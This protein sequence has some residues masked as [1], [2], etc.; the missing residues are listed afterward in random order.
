MAV[1]PGVVREE[2]DLSLYAEIASSHVFGVVGLFTKGPIGT[3]TA[4]SNASDLVNKFGKPKTTFPAWYAARQYLRAG[5]QLRVVRMESASSPAEAGTGALRGAKITTLESGADGDAIVAADATEFASAGSTFQTNNVQ[6]GDYLRI[7]SGANSGYY[8]VITAVTSETE[9]HVSPDLAADE[10][11]LNFEV[12]TGIRQSKDDGATSVP[13]TRQLTSATGQFLNLAVEAG[14][15]VV[16]AD[17]GTPEDNQLYTVVSVQNAT[18]LTVDRNWPKGS[19]AGLTYSIYAP[20][21]AG[22]DGVTN[23]TAVFTSAGSKFQSTGVL[24]GDLLEIE[25]TIDTGDNAVYKIASV[26]SET[27]L[28]LETTTTVP[29]GLT[30][31]AFQVW[32]SALVGTAIEKGTHASDLRFR[33]TPSTVSRTLYDLEIQQSGVTVEKFYGVD[34]NNL[35][36]VDNAH[37]TFASSVGILT[38][39]AHNEWFSLVGGDDGDTGV[40]DA[41]YI[42]TATALA[43]TAL[44]LFRHPDAVALK[45]LAV[46]GVSTEAVGNELVAIT[47]ERGDI[48]AFLDPPSSA[49]VDSVQDVL[50]WTNG[51]LGRTTAINSNQVA[52]YWPWFLV[53]DEYNAQDVACAPSGA[54]AMAFSTTDKVAA[55]WYAPAGPARGRVKGATDLQYNPTNP[56]REQ[57]Y[58]PGQIVNPISKIG[59]RGVIIFGQKTGQRANTSLNRLNVRRMLNYVQKSIATATQELL[60]EPN[61]STTRRR[62]VDLSTPLLQQ[63]Q[64]QR[65]IQEFRVVCDESNNPPAIVDANQ[66]RAAIYIRPTKTAEIIV[67]QTVLTSQGA[68]FNELIQAAA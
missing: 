39:P 58:A 59:T 64:A 55:E 11:S 42:G 10:A 50:D 33:A 17:A 63:V 40:V 15:L 7:T 46:P 20:L 16:I 41:D 4:V 27:Q 65:G 25:D 60:F 13:A 3:V 49:T 52:V 45:T 62:F 68:N 51:L 44:Q 34:R 12:V 14:D 5:N 24:V 28:T 30:G 35:A 31:L 19:G 57:L 53:Y 22:I 26:D 8:G 2:I 6:V 48:I 37:I 47:E 23:G 21:E 18:T 36:A 66:M 61:D 43:T 32:P 1:S 67:V 38:N 54:A 56:D 29:G 9:I